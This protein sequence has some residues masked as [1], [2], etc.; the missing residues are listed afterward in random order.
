LQELTTP[1]E[2]LNNARMMSM[3][4]RNADQEFLLDRAVRDFDPEFRRNK[5]GGD[6]ALMTVVFKGELKSSLNWYLSRK[7]IGDIESSAAQI[8][9]KPT[10]TS[11]LRDRLNAEE[12][13]SLLLP[14]KV[15]AAAAAPKT[16]G[17]KKQ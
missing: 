15:R 17:V 12:L 8:F 1:V 11:T 2:G 5:P 14:F 16:D 9:S 13:E 4:I 3:S 6:L 10:P 7:D